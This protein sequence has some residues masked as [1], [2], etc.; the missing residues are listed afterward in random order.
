M[1]ALALPTV[2]RSNQTLILPDGRTLGFAEYGAEKGTPIFLFHGG[3]G[4]RYLGADWD[5]DLRRHN[6]RLISVDRPGMGLSTL[7]PGRKVA[8]WA[9]DIL[10]LADHL[11]IQEIRVL[12]ASAGGPYALSCAAGLPSERLKAVG[13]VVGFGP[14]DAGYAGMNWGLRIQVYLGTV[15]PMWV[16]EWAMGGYLGMAP[17]AM[18]KDKEVLRNM[19]WK[20]VD[21]MPEGE[22]KSLCCDE[23]R[24][25]SIEMIRE[26]YRQGVKGFVEDGLLLMS[27][28]GFEVK[29]IGFEGLLLWY[30]GADD[31]VPPR[32]G[33]WMKEQL[34]TAVLKVFEGENHSVVWL[35]HREEFL[36]AMLAER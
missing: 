26:A 9:N 28:W 18:N 27:N 29:D 33:R 24:L 12:G 19:M 31:H 15:L 32:V 14:W 8:D 4:C 11:G 23:G 2:P 36:K 5:P 13:V 22:E 3:P 10:R 7:N 20:M 25:V 1:S 30:G 35:K 6:A 16:V 34:P 21:D 17:A